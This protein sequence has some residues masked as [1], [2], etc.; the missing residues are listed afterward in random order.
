MKNEVFFCPTD[1]L[2]KYINPKWSIC[3]L[4]RLCE[5]K[6]RFTELERELKG[7]SSK[8]LTQRLKM[9]EKD[10]IIT[11]TVIPTVP[12]QV[13][14]SLTDYGRSFKAIIHIA[15]YWVTVNKSRNFLSFNPQ[16]IYF[17]QKIQQLEN[18]A[19]AASQ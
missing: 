16:C 11:R 18:V 10:G 6:K 9:F 15:Q 8:V 7:I 13:E 3:I 4:C 14:Y 19:Y 1:V 12:I 2:R 17:K 5:G